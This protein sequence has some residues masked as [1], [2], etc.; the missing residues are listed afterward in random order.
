MDRTASPRPG[1]TLVELLV[2]ITIIGILVSMLL[3]AVN[4]VREAGRSTTCKSNMRQLAMA[5]DLYHAKR[6]SLP[7]GAWYS[8]TGSNENW[9]LTGFGWTALH[10]ILPYIDQEAIYNA[11]SFTPRQGDSN[12]QQNAIPIIPGSN[13][14]R[15]VKTFVVPNFV[16]PSDQSR[17]VVPG[18]TT[19]L[20]NYVGSAG[21][22]AVSAVGA[23]NCK[24]S[25]PYNVYVPK[26]PSP[27]VSGPFRVHNDTSTWYRRPAVSYP[28]IRDGQ[29]NTILMGEIR[30]GCSPHIGGGW[31]VSTNG[32][33]IISTIIP[34]NVYTCEPFQSCQSG[35]PCKSLNNYS[36][37]VGFKAA[38]PG[39]ANFSMC[40]GS[41]HFLSEGIDH[42]M[43]QYLGACDDMQPTRIP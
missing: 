9:K 1:F 20:S 37:S 25:Q 11:F 2:V 10:L 18:S 31:A 34:I 26:N 33:G 14:R 22:T 35:D 17:G 4:Q 5:M 28:M 6:G 32:C 7:M 40:D 38:H 8:S 30:Y 29:A 39:G 15:S 13:P 3:P 43:Y 21:A 36:L 24:C 12:A 19:A 27:K 16:C 41:V 42:Q 23:Y